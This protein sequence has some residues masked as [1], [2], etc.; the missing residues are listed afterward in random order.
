MRYCVYVTWSTPTWGYGAS[1][2]RSGRLV[3]DSAYG[4]YW[5]K[6]KKRADAMAECMRQEHPGKTVHV[7][8]CCD[9]G[10]GLS[11]KC[12]LNDNGAEPGCG[13]VRG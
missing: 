10:R 8:S 9:A 13:D 7:E 3:G 12:W 6:S 2:N 11:S 1:V 4:G 5:W